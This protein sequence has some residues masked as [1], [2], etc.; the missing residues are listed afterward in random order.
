VRAGGDNEPERAP[1]GPPR[2][3]RQPPALGPA[4]PAGVAGLSHGLRPG[5]QLGGPLS[6]PRARTAGR[7]GAGL[8]DHSAPGDSATWGRERWAGNVYWTGLGAPGGPGAALPR[9]LS[10]RWPAP[11]QEAEVGVERQSGRETSMR[12]VQR[13]RRDTGTLSP[14]SLNPPGPLLPRVS[15]IRRPSDSHP[16]S[17][18]PHC[19]PGRYF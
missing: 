15:P 14:S 9:L 18:E 19:R 6:L 13:G 3:A 16:G 1:P 17:P 8:L 4:P 12:P 10:P 7:A 5:A 11:G 2:A